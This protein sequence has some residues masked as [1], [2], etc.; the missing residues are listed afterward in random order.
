MTRRQMLQWGLY[1]GLF[2]CIVGIVLEYG[3][4]KRAWMQYVSYETQ[5]ETGLFAR[6]ARDCLDRG[7]L[8]GF[9][10][11]CRQSQRDRSTGKTP[12][13]ANDSSSI[14]TPPE[15]FGLR[16]RV[17]LF[18]K[19]GTVLFDTWHPVSEME[20]HANRPEFK[21]VL[22][23]SKEMMSFVTFERYST[24]IQTN[25]FF[26][27]T[28][29][30]AG[31]DLYLL[32]VGSTVQAV[33]LA[34]NDGRKIVLGVVI[35]SLL[36]AGIVIGLYASKVFYY[37][38]QLLEIDRQ[39]LGGPGSASGV[40]TGR[41]FDGLIRK[42]RGE[43]SSQSEQLV[44]EREIRDI[45]FQSLVEG[46][47]LLDAKGHIIDVN[48]GA[49]RLLDFSSDSSRG[50]F[51]FDLWRNT[52]FEQF[53]KRQEWKTTPSTEWSLE[54]PTGTRTIDV[55][56][57]EVP[58][59][60]NER[61]FLLLLYDLT[62]LKRLENY[63]RDF[64]ANVSHEIKTP[65][66]VIMGTVD[67]LQDDDLDRPTANGFLQTLSLHA[68]RLYSLVQDVLSLS[69][70]ESNIERNDERFEN[71]S[72]LLSLELAVAYCEPAAQ[73]AN[74]RIAIENNA[75]HDVIR[76]VPDLMEQAFINLIDNAVKYAAGDQD[77]KKTLHIG[78][79]NTAKHELII[80]FTDEGPGIA[81][82]H[83]ERIFE[84]FYRVD[85]SRSAQTGGTGLGLA[86]VKHIVQY[87]G[88]TVDVANNPTGG[89]TFSIVLPQSNG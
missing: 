45:I 30:E 64:I 80:R 36:I 35:L 44:R 54:L 59:G 79:S 84:R 19:D 1:A 88:G 57:S 17:T 71:L 14:F 48:A 51:L 60:N 43:I 87:H 70:L 52:A 47:V 18:A 23:G 78:L 61:G 82:S 22:T 38:G 7:D 46:V 16:S 5:V 2:F 27:I 32:R 72:A 62:S 33:R 37:H 75:D 11:F 77:N 65:L 41:T 58:L 50:I 13:G 66:T 83:R 3:R 74:L 9:E 53:F 49:A 39:Y 24:T 21:A 34:G 28:K 29:F 73:K 15:K 76:Q 81:K 67:A 56:V 4:M 63:R 8:Q 69:N 12:S 85:P 86:I 10:Q 31:N 68:K 20:N 25:M 55:R 42:I 26:C 6:V 89:C 40:R